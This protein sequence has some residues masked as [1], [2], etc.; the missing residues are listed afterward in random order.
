MKIP[1]W[2]FLA[3]AFAINPWNAFF[4]F[5]LPSFVALV[6]TSW[7]TYEHHAGFHPTSHYDASTNRTSPIYN[8]LTCN[9]GYHTAHHKRPGVHW[10]LLP[11]IHEEIK[12]EIPENMIIPTF[13]GMGH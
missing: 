4:V 1:V 2:G 5:L 7:A 12:H 13:F 6:H 9:L 11:K 10:S 8:F 3:V